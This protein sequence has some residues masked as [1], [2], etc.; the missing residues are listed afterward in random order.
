MSGHWFGWRNGHATIAEYF[1]NTRQFLGV[2]HR[3]GGGM[4]INVIHIGR[5]N[6]RI[7]WG[8][9]LCQAW[10]QYHRAQCLSGDRHRR[11]TASN[12]FSINSGSAFQSMFKLFKHQRAGTFTNNKPIAAF[13]KGREA[14]SGSALRLESVWAAEKP[15]AEA[16][17]I[18]A[19]EPPVIIISAL[20]SR[21]VSSALIIAVLMRHRP[22]PGSNWGHANGAVS[23]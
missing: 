4:R 16:G 19:S 12:Y 6:A 17:V 21:M 3:C 1:V 23:K 8:L 2:A 20:L 7:P 11:H 5:R 10:L 18:A 9:L 14:F 13:I 15:P 22:K